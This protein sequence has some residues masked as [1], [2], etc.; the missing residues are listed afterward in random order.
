MKKSVFDNFSKL[1]HEKNIREIYL[2]GSMARGDQDEYSD[3]DILI[4]IDNCLEDEYIKLKDKYASCLDVPVSWV[5]VY[6]IN[7]ILNMHKIGSYFLWHIKKEGKV[8]Y[9]RDDELASLLLTL[10]KYA[11]VEKDI[12]EYSEIL[13]DIE[14]E[15]ENELMCVE[16]ELAV[17]ASLIRNT[18]I[19]ISYLSERLDFGR[20]SV[21]LFCFSKYKLNITMKEYEELYKYRLYHTGKINTVPK[22]KIAQLIKWIRIEKELLEIAKRGV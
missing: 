10:P 1:K 6:R 9:S 5:S 22:G 11:N 15:L 19:A 18:C 7:K 12:D 2:F 21:V 8:I 3:M 14:R 16:Y 13:L 17:M 4:V 20:N